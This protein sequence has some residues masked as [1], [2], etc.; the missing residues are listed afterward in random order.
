MHLA[1][2]TGPPIELLML[3]EFGSNVCPAGS[4]GI[5]TEM[6]CQSGVA[7]LGFVY[8]KNLS[9]SAYPKGCYGNGTHAWLNTT[10][11]KCPG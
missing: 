11:S 6:A 2:A 9:N 3:G 1:S 7:T 8:A 10:T 5:G 4:G